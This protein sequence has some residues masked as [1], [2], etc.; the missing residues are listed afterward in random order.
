MPR[1]RENL[2]KITIRLRAGDAEAID[3]FHPALGHNKVIRG[4]VA[5][6]VEK[7][8]ARERRLPGEQLDQTTADLPLTDIEL[9]EDVDLAIRNESL[10]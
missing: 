3:A 9:D 2:H 7:L 8:K 10:Q 6:Y 5:R 4:L 1:P